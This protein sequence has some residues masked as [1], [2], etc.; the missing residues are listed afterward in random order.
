MGMLAEL[1]S[2]LGLRHRLRDP[3]AVKHAAQL[4]WWI[5]RWEPIVRGGGLTPDDTLAYLDDAEPAPTY[6]GRRWQIARAHVGRVL[7][8][9]AIDDGGF[10]DD[11]V[12][13]DLGC[14]P[15]GFPDACA[16]RV[17]IG[18][19]PLVEAY[20]A[21]GLLLPDS[22]A[23]YM[24]GDAEQIPLLSSS[25]DVV[26][27][28][29][30][31][32][33]VVDPE[34][35]AREMRRILRPSGTLIVGFDVDQTPTVAQPQALTVERVRSALAGMTVTH[36]REWDLPFATSGHRVVLVAVRDVGREV[37]P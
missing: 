27:A 35:S 14:G 9:A 36:R 16:A 24:R 25:V 15:V 29:D 8:E 12:V 5:E 33:Y 10:F 26:V 23:V 13:V 34:Q 2:R 11:K 21:H 30:V 7:D 3:V 28:R 37:E 32:D 31:L 1:R 6:L 4:R 18:V 19:D 22:R 17:S 20:A